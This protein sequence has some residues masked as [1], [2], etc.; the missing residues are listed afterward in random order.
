MYGRRGLYTI[1]AVFALLLVSGSVYAAW[2]GVLNF[3]GTAELNQTFRLNIV[4]AEI[5]DKKDSE[6]IHVSTPAGETLT[7][8]VELDAPNDTRY[9]KFAIKNVGNLPAVLGELDITDPEEDTGVKVDWPDLNDMIIAPWAT[10]AEQTIAV[11]WDPD[12]AGSTT[13]TAYLSATVNYEQHMP[14]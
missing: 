1:A 14:E 10:T 5:T 13:L 6:S 12:F 4:D 2:T 3:N 9:V 7:F 11:H 8:S